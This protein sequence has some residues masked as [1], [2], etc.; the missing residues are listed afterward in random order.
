MT[1][2]LLALDA[3]VRPDDE[4]AGEPL[5]IGVG[6]LPD[7]HPPWQRRAD[8]AEVPRRRVGYPTCSEHLSRY[9][10]D[11]WL[12]PTRWPRV[13]DATPARAMQHEPSFRNPG[14][15]APDSQL[16]TSAHKP[17]PRPNK[18]FSQTDTR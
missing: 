5:D 15:V 3:Q 7:P 10:Q 11:H 12:R 8:V 9:R 2:A 16:P 17:G 18:A 13:R 14:H 6:G 4:Q 1:R